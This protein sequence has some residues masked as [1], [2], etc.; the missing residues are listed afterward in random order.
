VRIQTDYET[1]LTLAVFASPVQAEEAVLALRS[2]AVP[3]EAIQLTALGSGTY[4][5]VDPFL[6]EEFSGVLSG[7]G[8]GAPIG[9]ALAVGVAMPLAA[10][11]DV[12]AWLAVAGFG[13]GALVGS[14]I[15]SAVGAHY[16]DDIAQEIYISPDSLAVIVVTETS[17]YHTRRARVALSRA[18]AIGFLD[19]SLYP[20]EEEWRPMRPR[21]A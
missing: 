18:G 16:D 4:Q 15:G 5:C 3:D 21:A 13:A 10:T 11:W 7:A 17:N 2:A 8:F 12:V 14:I 20:P 6:G 1:E 19:P 9:A